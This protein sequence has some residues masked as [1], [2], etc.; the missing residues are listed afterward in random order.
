MAWAIDQTCGSPSAKVTLWAIANHANLETWLAWAAQ[1]YYVEE[2]EQSPDSIQ[3]RI[4]DLEERGL[5]KRMPLRFDGRKSTDLFILRPSPLWAASI[6][7]IEKQLPRGL[8]VDPKFAAKYDPADCGS[9]NIATAASEQPQTLPQPAENVAATVRQQEPVNKPGNSERARAREE[10]EA[11]PEDIEAVEVTFAAMVRVWPPG[12]V[13]DVKAAKMALLALSPERRKAAVDAAPRY[14][15]ALRDEKRRYTPAIGT[16]LVERTFERFPEPDKDASVPSVQLRPYVKEIYAL[17]WGAVPA[18]ITGKGP[19]DRVR[20]YLAWLPKGMLIPAA[21]LPRAD[22]LSSLV[23][24]AV[25]SP[26]HVAW[27]EYGERVGIRLPVPDIVRVIYVPSAWPPPL[28]VSWKAYHMAVPIRVEAR[29]RAWWWRLYIDG[30]PVQ[31]LLRDRTVGAVEMAMGPVA[32]RREVEA[33]VEIEVGSDEFAKWEIWFAGK[34][35]RL[36]ALGGSIFAPTSYPP[37]GERAQ[38]PDYEALEEALSAHG[39]EVV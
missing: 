29:S 23:P 28:R 4:P 20:N 19:S 26:E 22:E 6:E 21:S 17:L 13:G 38:A 11:S 34:D 36:L 7:D 35:V 5:L 16:Y 37:S 8:T 9:D 30:A 3:R 39:R 31:D 32:L 33:M 12:A 10:G 2:T 18:A 24:I 25:G 14:L 15:R 1:S 27:L